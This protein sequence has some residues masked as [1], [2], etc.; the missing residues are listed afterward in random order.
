MA[1]VLASQRRPG[2]NRGGPEVEKPRKHGRHALW[3]PQ[4]REL[5]HRHG[6]PDHF[7]GLGLR[8]VLTSRPG[9]PGGADHAGPEASV[10]AYP[11]GA[12]SGCNPPWIFRAGLRETD[13]G[14]QSLANPYLSSPA[15][16]CST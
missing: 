5:G 13:S 10:Q 15:E 2:F 16:H 4:K 14:T 6:L 7:H 11:G 9:L 12:E 8:G 1:R 3:L